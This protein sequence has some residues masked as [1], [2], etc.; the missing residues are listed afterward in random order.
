MKPGNMLFCITLNPDIYTKVNLKPMNLVPAPTYCVTAC[1]V[2]AA[3][4]AGTLRLWQIVE[5][6]VGDDLRDHDDDDGGGA[7]GGEV[8][9]VFDECHRAKNLVTRT[10]SST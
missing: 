5:W 7:G 9:V 1:I 10:D 4:A 2:V 3:A 6:L 8:L